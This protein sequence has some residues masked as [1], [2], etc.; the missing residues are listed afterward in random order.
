MNKPS[1]WTKGFSIITSTTFFAV[2]N[3]YLLMVIIPAFAM[4]SFHSSPSEAGLASSIFVIG[5]LIAR[6]FSGKWI[7]RIGRK[8]TLYAGLVSGFV[9]TLLYFGINDV[10]FLF[11][12][13]FLHGATYG[14]TTTATATIVSSTIPKERC[15][16]GFAYYTSS[17]T[18]ATAVGP[19]LG[20]FISQHAS[21]SMI[22]AVCAI[23]AALSLANA[24][25]LTIPEVKLTKEQL[26]E[27]KGFHF[28]SFVESRAIPISLVCGV[29]AFCYSGVLAFLVTYSRGIHLANAASFFFVVYAAAILLS[30][31]YTG[32]LFDSKGE[33]FAMYP[34]II[35]FMIGMIVLGQAHYGYT[36]LLA[37]AVM[38]LGLGTIQSA[39]QAIAV[40]VASPH[41]L[42]LANSTY[43]MCMDT[44]VGV[45]P[46]IL[47]IF[48]P[49]TGYRGLYIDIAIVALACAPLYYLLHGRRAV[50]GI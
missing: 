37:G 6:L 12:I 50:F 41:R 19:F 7:E 32:R 28:N 43:F 47:G 2:L 18:L 27:T 4:D 13:R 46:F 22:F 25:F 26:E 34:A 48:I 24:L 36:V 42:G 35:L 20:M 16:E 44:A 5:S 33:N 17:F 1:L 11:L 21:F 30:R 45:G 3:F 39:G 38:G 10:M 49:F 14:I 29:L 15:G 40:K 8:R 23:F 31:P 9:M